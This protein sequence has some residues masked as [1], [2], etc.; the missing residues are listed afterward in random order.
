MNDIVCSRPD[1]NDALE[2][3]NEALT[4]DVNNVSYS[5]R[6]YNKRVSFYF[7]SFCYVVSWGHSGNTNLGG[8]L[9]TVDL[10]IRY[11]VL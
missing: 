5:T 7:M 11:L 4:R 2:I 1:M 6:I 3:E 8:R 9:S 10:L